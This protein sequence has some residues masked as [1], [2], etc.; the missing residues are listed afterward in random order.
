MQITHTDSANSVI[1][2]L[3][4]NPRQ[5]GHQQMTHSE[6]L[7]KAYDLAAA[8][9]RPGY[10]IEV[11][12]YG[13]CDIEVIEWEGID[14]YE[15]ATDSTPCTVFNPAKVLNVKDLEIVA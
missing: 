10:A 9:R 4:A 5:K 14:S 7:S 3:S 13:P 6:V 2:V 11:R 15:D 1:I 12:V 8:L